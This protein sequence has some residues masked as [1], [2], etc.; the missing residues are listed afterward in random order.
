MIYIATIVILFA[1]IQFFTAWINF[2]F[3]QHPLRGKTGDNDLVSVLIPARNEEKN[4]GRLLASINQLSYS[5]I[6]I[7]VFDDQSEDNTASIVEQKA[8]SDSR[9]RLIRSEG[10]PEGWLGKNNA[11]HQLAKEACGQWLLFLDA[12][13]IPENSIIEDALGRMKR[14]KLGLLSMFPIQ[15]MNTN[16]EWI[17]VPVMNYILLSLLPLL[18]VRISPFTSHS[19]ANGQFMFFDANIYRELLP[20]K[21]F[22]N[23]P[24]E[25]INISRYYK[26]NGVKV[27]CIAASRNISCRMY[28]GFKDAVNGF[29]K[30]IL[31]FF[32]NSAIVAVLF[33]LITT[34]GFIPVALYDIQALWLYLAVII[35]TR[36]FISSTSR[37]NMFK[38]LVFMITQ[39]FV[40]G[41]IIF[42]AIGIRY[43]KGNYQ[44]KGRD[45][46]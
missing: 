41:F 20:H 23:S 14:H 43:K 37:Q 1:V 21:K 36:V 12:D 24:V 11:C 44:W 35:L 45:I 39:H 18:F 4:I 25:D 6:E 19:A 10:L 3:P 34:L 8:K 28:H 33:W 5:N 30:N 27:A 7:L 13:V 15:E 2:V 16:G 22:K 46:S 40:M 42:R 32:G 31:M 29:T 26:K 17:T 38:N 9:V